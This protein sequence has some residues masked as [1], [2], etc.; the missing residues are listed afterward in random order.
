MLFPTVLAIVLLVNGKRSYW[1]QCS[2]LHCNLTQFQFCFKANANSIEPRIVNGKPAKPGQA[3]YQVSIQWEN[4][5]NPEVPETTGN[6]ENPEVPEVPKNSLVRAFTHF[7]GGSIMNERWV[8]TAGHCI[9]A[10]PDGRAVQIVAGKHMLNE[11]EAS[12]QVSDILFKVVHKDYEGWLSW[13]Y[14]F[15]LYKWITNK[16]SW[17]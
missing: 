16:L 11:D 6:P 3:P 7:C 1:Q 9:L 17:E 4:Q 10:I 5:E 8:L 13:I 14:L 12:E 2:K 15:F